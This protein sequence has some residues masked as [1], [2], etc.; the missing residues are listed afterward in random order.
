MNLN[1]EQLE[2]LIN[3]FSEFP[4][5]EATFIIHA[6]WGE[7]SPRDIFETLLN[8]EVRISSMEKATA[9]LRIASIGGRPRV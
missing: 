1:R 8:F 6:S 4:H 2:E 5:E 9:F 3:L 7:V